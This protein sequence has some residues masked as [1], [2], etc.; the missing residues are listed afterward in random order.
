MRS[1]EKEKQDKKKALIYIK[2]FEE[3]RKQVKDDVQSVLSML[4]GDVSRKKVI[5]YI[6]GYLLKN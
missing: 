4:G 6:K 1:W 5:K 3:G 2:G